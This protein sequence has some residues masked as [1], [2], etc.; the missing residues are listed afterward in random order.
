[1]KYKC[2]HIQFINTIIHQSLYVSDTHTFVQHDNVTAGQ[3]RITGVIG[4]PL[5][6]R[7]AVGVRGWAKWFG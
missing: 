2:M 1:M 7:Q 6:I 5:E 3:S 4:C